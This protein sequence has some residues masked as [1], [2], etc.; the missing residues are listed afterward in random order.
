MRV[1]LNEKRSWNPSFMVEAFLKDFKHILK[2]RTGKIFAPL[3]DPKLAMDSVKTFIESYS[4]WRK[5]NPVPPERKIN[6]DETGLVVDVERLVGRAILYIELERCNLHLPSPT[7]HVSMLPFVTASGETLM[8]VFVVSAEPKEGG[9]MATTLDANALRELSGYGIPVYFAFNTNGYIGHNLWVKIIE[10]LIVLIGQPGTSTCYELFLDNSS[11]HKSEALEQHCLHHG[12]K[13]VFLP[14]RCTPF[15]QPLDSIPFA[16][17]KKFIK[18]E[19]AQDLYQAAC[20][21]GDLLWFLIRATL[22]VLPK[23]FSKECVAKAWRSTGLEPWDPDLV[24]EMAKTVLNPNDELSNGESRNPLYDAA[25]EIMPAVRT[26]MKQPRITVKR[27]VPQNTLLTLDA[28]QNSLENP[29]EVFMTSSNHNFSPRQIIKLRDQFHMNEK[30]VHL[31]RAERRIHCF[32]CG[33]KPQNPW[34]LSYCTEPNCEVQ[35]CNKCCAKNTVVDYLICHE[36]H[37]TY[38][39]EIEEDNH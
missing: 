19:V 10:K 1:I 5:Q 26:L 16:A 8:V 34:Y 28:L 13:L 32:L 11:V 14:P 25:V 23:A 39:E 2:L 31:H 37:C 21:K 29:N 4:Q 3:P 27:V 17:M 20:G 33:R 22:R 36:A 35:I 12:I 24:L 18:S 15:L 30:L 9:S 38:I 6:A 7:G